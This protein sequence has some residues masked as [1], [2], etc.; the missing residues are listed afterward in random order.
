MNQRR[1]KIAVGVILS[2]ALLNVSILAL[3][4]SKT[5]PYSRSIYIGLISSLRERGYRF[6]L[7]RDYQVN[8]SEKV[9]LLRHDVDV[10]IRGV[11]VLAEIEKQF[12]VR[13][14]FY[15]RMDGDYFGES[16][17]IF[18]QLEREG[19]EIGFHYDTLSRSNGDKSL[20]TPLFIA[21][22]AF[23]RSLFNISTTVAHGDSHNPHIWN[24]ALFDGEL[25]ERLGL[26]DFT[27]VENATYISDSSHALSVPS[28]FKN[29][30]LIN[31]HTDYW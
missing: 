30:V 5:A 22:V 1:N 16:Y 29:V 19:F 27:H 18:Q 24:E 26:R 2:L 4:W 10:R 7:P 14:A 6:I 31:L 15:V 23:M 3:V 25:W 12:G 11:S 20:A 17:P 8:A 28:E 21:Q 13:S 9:V